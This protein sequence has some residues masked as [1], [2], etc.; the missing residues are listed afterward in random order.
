MK[1]AANIL[2]A[3]VGQQPR[4]ADLSKLSHLEPGRLVRGLDGSV[5]RVAS[6]VRTP[7]GTVLKLANLQGKPAQT[8]A[9]F[10]PVS[11]SMARFASWMRYH[12]AYNRDFDLYINSYIEQWNNSHPDEKP[13]PY[14]IGRDG[15]P[16]QWAKW[17]QASI[18]PKLHTPV[19]GP[20]AD[21]LRDE[22]I[23]EMLFTVLGKRNILDQFRKKIKGF[24]ELH[25]GDEARQITDWLVSSFMYRIGD[26]Q[27]KINE[28]THAEEVSMW[29]PGTEEGDEGEI[30]ILD[31]EEHGVEPDTL[32]EEEEREIA[33]FREGFGKWLKTRLKPDVAENFL[34]LFDLNWEVVKDTAEPSIEEERRT[35]K[36]KEQRSRW[37]VK[38]EELEKGWQER[39]GMSFGALKEYKGRLPGLMRDYITE[40][41]AALGESSVFPSLIKQIEKEAP[42]GK[43]KPAKASSLNLAAQEG[44]YTCMKCH[45]TSKESD[46]NNLQCPHCGGSMLEKTA[47]GGRPDMYEEYAEEGRQDKELH[48]EI[49]QREQAANTVYAVFEQTSDQYGKEE[50]VALCAT[51]AIADREAGQI[52]GNQVRVQPMKVKTAG[53]NPPDEGP[54]Y[55]DFPKNWKEEETQETHDRKQQARNPNGLSDVQGDAIIA[56]IRPGDRVTILVPAGMGRGGQEWKEST[57]RAVI[58]SPG[59]VAL[60]MGGRHGTPGVATAQNVVSVRKAKRG[61]EELDH[62]SGAA[63]TAKLVAGADLTP[64]MRKQVEAAFIYRWTYDNQRRTDV[65]HC[66]KCDLAQQP[67]VNEKSSEGHQHPTVPLISD[68]QWIREH[69]FHFTNDG[70]LHP[71]QR[72]A[73]P[74]YLAQQSE[75]RVASSQQKFAVL[76]AAY[77]PGPAEYIYQADT[78]CE[79]CANAIKKQLSTSGNVPTNL[80]ETQ[81]DSDSYPKG[82]Y[83]EQEADA[84]QHCARCTRFLENPLTQAGYEYLREMVREHQVHGRG[85][86][87][88][89]QEWV[90]FYPEAFEGPDY[91]PQGEVDETI[92]PLGEDAAKDFDAKFQKDVGF[93]A[94]VKSAGDQPCCGGFKPNHRPDCKKYNDNFDETVGR[95][96]LKRSSYGIY[97]CP[98]CGEEVPETMIGQGPKQVPMGHCP[99]C[100]GE[101]KALIH[102]C[103]ECEHPMDRHD[104]KYGCEYDL[105]DAP[106]GE[107]D[108]GPYGSYARGECGCKYGLNPDG[109]E[110]EGMLGHDFTDGIRPQDDYTPDTGRQNNQADTTE[111]HQPRLGAADLTKRKSAPNTVV[112]QVCND[113]GRQLGVLSGQYD[114]TPEDMVRVAQLITDQMFDEY[115]AD[116]SNMES[117]IVATDES[118]VPRWKISPNFRHVEEIRKTAQGSGSTTVTM[119]NQNATIP[120]TMGQK[121]PMAVPDAIDQSPGPHSPNAP[122]TAPR[123]PSIQPRIVDVPAG[124]VGEDAMVASSKMAGLNVVFQNNQGFVTDFGAPQQMTSGGQPA[125]EIP[126]YGVW[127][128]QPGVKG[129]RPQVTNTTNDLDEAKGFLGE[130]AARDEML[131]RELGQ[132]KLRK[133]MLEGGNPGTGLP[134]TGLRY[135]DPEDMWEKESAEVDDETMG[136]AMELLDKQGAAV[137]PGQTVSPNV[138]QNMAIQPG[139]QS[140]QQSPT[141][142]AIMPG[143]GEEGGPRERK[144][145][146][147]EL[148][149][150]KYHM[151]GSF[152]DTAGAD[153]LLA[154]EQSRMGQATCENCGQ[155]KPDVQF[156]EFPDL[157]NADGTDILTG[158]F[159][160]D[161]ALDIAQDI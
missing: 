110:K 61:A 134:A 117:G 74:A 127:Q 90:D 7:D 36:E 115:G 52:R 123:T 87:E 119:Q 113:D 105:G 10:R 120:G 9:D 28:G 12:L 108:F 135:G 63:K 76:K 84:P 17:F 47:D 146:E 48:D 137:A 11:L 130:P 46:C 161:C 131:E 14:P 65:Y 148:P 85:K 126:R 41:A 125:G 1:D 93:K 37:E 147:P 29:Q 129:G 94:S 77:N 92:A 55:Y 34:A 96:G 81:Y 140:M 121:E 78:Y 60:N 109:I 149:G 27:E 45:R 35:K 72:H 40:N 136:R 20:D 54:D 51:Q 102:L 150:A 138:Q 70:R 100:K 83:H 26:M 44:E 128:S 23:H 86:D 56:Q 112:R 141:S 25:Q 111:L 31:T 43:G 145:I 30:N 101:A 67:Y 64:E 89:I 116:C 104:G 73:E 106:G 82:P 139:L 21:A 88:V 6:K 18:A 15:K 122:A 57:G 68:D 75:G 42:K 91:T 5:F 124:T 80:D 103:P 98:D 2:G 62:K 97:V 39:T 33:K 151:S 154:E 50:L 118:G 58:V 53:D 3:V 132:Q 19:K 152:Y 8:P 32:R 153:D 16:M 133:D 144:T 158:H 99:G 156:H 143:G 142:V 95:L 157:G 71:R 79:D 49:A 4:K 114:G 66:D 69:A 107:G 59:H 160:N 22:A 24:K 155:A 159:C 13:I 38:R